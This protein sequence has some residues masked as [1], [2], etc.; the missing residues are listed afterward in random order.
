VD[1]TSLV[2]VGLFG[3]CGWIDFANGSVPGQQ[4]FEAMHGVVGDA[5]Q[6]VG[7]IRFRV[8][9]IEFCCSDQGIDR[10]PVFAAGIRSLKEMFFLPSAIARRLLSAALLSISRRPSLT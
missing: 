6:H 8:E 1:T 9:V 4:F 7:K 10:G 2:L 5:C 3:F